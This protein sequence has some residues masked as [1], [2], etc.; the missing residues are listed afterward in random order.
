MPL[1]V[2]MWNS[3]KKEKNWKICMPGTDIQ[4]RNTDP[5]SVWDTN[6]IQK[7]NT[8]VCHVNEKQ[9]KVSKAL[10]CFGVLVGRQCVLQLQLGCIGLGVCVY[11][12]V[13]FYSSSSLSSNG[14]LHFI[15]NVS[16]STCVFHAVVKVS[17]VSTHSL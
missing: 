6:D 11:V 5:N 15:C 1:M 12:W 3:R 16:M 4:I 17:L 7:F 13:V 8:F 14:F 10:I 9:V 2:A